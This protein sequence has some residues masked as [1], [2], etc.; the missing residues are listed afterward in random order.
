M[1]RPPLSSS[2]PTVI[3]F[4]ILHCSIFL[5]HKSAQ[6]F[7]SVLAFLIDFAGKFTALVHLQREWISCFIFQILL[8]TFFPWA[9][10]VHAAACIK[11]HA[12]HRCL[13]SMIQFFNFM[14]A[15]D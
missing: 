11:R 5:R 14:N 7:F 10:T 8:Y 13:T 6:F 9:G 12:L 3:T 15:D 1:V 2:R 4:F